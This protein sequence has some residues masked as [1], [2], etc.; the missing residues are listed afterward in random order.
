MDQS[1]N[2]F[3]LKSL[4]GIEVAL[5]IRARGWCMKRMT[6]IKLKSK[7]RLKKIITILRITKKLRT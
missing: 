5:S 6:K 1:I 4:R 2:Q 3:Y 7:M